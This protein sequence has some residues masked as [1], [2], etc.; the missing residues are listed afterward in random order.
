M[1]ATAEKTQRTPA[2]T[3]VARRKTPF[4]RAAE[5]GGALSAQPFFRG[6]RAGVQ[7]QLEVSQPDDPQEREADRAAD[8]VMNMADPGPPRVAAAQPKEVHRLAESDR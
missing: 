3:Q 6:G 7:T 1:N 8:R 4:F 2:A 5:G